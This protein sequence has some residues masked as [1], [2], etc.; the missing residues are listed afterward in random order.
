MDLGLIPLML[1][2]WPVCLLAAGVVA[3]AAVV[4]GVCLLLLVGYHLLQVVLHLLQVCLYLQQVVC[5][6]ASLTALL[7]L[8][9]HS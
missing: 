5:A 1:P 6:Q 7:C 9:V 4:E 2:C 8:A 3:A